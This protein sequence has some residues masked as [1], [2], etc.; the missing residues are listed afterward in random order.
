MSFEDIAASKCFVT[1]GTNAC[2]MGFAVAG[3]NMAIE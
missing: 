2:I 3:S 1:F